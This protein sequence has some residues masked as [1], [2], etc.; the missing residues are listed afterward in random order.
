MRHKPL[1]R[2]ESVIINKYC[3]D[4]E[5]WPSASA[6]LVY[7]C[8]VSFDSLA[9]HLWS[10]SYLKAFVTHTHTHTQ[11]PKKRGLLHQM[12]A[13]DDTTAGA[14]VAD[15]R[16]ELAINVRLGRVANKCD[17]I[18]PGITEYVITEH[19][20]AGAFGEVYLCDVVSTPSKKV[21]AKIMETASV[22]EA[23]MFLVTMEINCAKRVKNFACVELLEA[24]MIENG[25]V[26]LILEYMSRGSLGRFLRL[27]YTNENYPTQEIVERYVCPL[28]VAL[29]HIHSQNLVHRDIK[30]RNILIG[31]YMIPK[32]SDFG[33][34]KVIHDAHLHN[35]NWAAVTDIGTREIFAPERCLG[36]GFAYGPPADVWSLGV[37][38]YKLVELCAPFDFSCI[39]GG[40]EMISSDSDDVGDHT[41]V[42]FDT[43]EPSH[44]EERAAA[45]KN[46]ASVILHQPVR[47]MTTNQ[48]VSENLKMI[49]L[50]MLE[51]Q[52]FHR[53]T[54]SQILRMP[55]VRGMVDRYSQVIDQQA[56]IPPHER[57]VI[58]NSIRG[59]VSATQ[60]PEH[61]RLHPVT[62][63]DT[64]TLVTPT[65]YKLY[66]LRVSP[67][68]TA[69]AVVENT[70][71]Q[72]SLR[73]LQQSAQDQNHDSSLDEE[74]H[75][76]LNECCVTLA[77][78][79]FFVLRTP[80]ANLSVCSLGAVY[81]V[82]LLNGYV[83]D[84]YHTH[85]ASPI[86]ATR[87]EAEGTDR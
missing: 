22:N 86:A 63:E 40:E 77:S 44:D 16:H 1:L 67:T 81:W 51:K 49:I 82:N 34:G 69:D 72:F 11:T 7:V 54:M 35:R 33:C 84:V 39:G 42:V 12:S 10:T 5:T 30:P 37:V 46:L 47:R 38:L 60:E 29:Y 23:T 15:L 41:R 9:I 19:L 71:T 3:R 56:D 55:Y 25:V 87:I 43:D 50:S 4:S 2:E 58:I 14:L 27:M 64:V 62:V 20:R 66:T 73:P 21:V 31:E 76:N 59:I 18:V 6:T 79:T 80:T 24:F 36:S 75:G 85:D 78:Q 17:P 52:P 74:Y 53:P 57:L 32:L 70:G 48:A 28:L 61:P 26:V 65:G 68:A 13:A 8:V 83:G 45:V